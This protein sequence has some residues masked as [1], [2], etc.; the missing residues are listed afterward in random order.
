MYNITRKPKN[1]KNLTIVILIT[2]LIIIT[3]CVQAISKNNLINKLIIAGRDISKLDR[4]Y[5][6]FHWKYNNKRQRKNSANDRK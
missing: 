1:K 2:A 5:E 6:F 3:L 4:R